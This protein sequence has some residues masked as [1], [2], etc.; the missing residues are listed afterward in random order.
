MLRDKVDESR[1]LAQSIQ[2]S[3]T[4]RKNAGTDR[5]VTASARL[6]A[7]IYAKH[8]T[9]ISRAAVPSHRQLVNDVDH[10]NGTIAGSMHALCAIDLYVPC[11]L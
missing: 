3:M 8:A 7:Q 4:T 11:A 5:G 1:E 10:V 9:A 6:H 2:R